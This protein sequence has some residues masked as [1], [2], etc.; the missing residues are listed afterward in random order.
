[1]SISKDFVFWTILWTIKKVKIRTVW[2]LT[3]DLPILPANLSKYNNNRKYVLRNFHYNM[4]IKIKIKNKI[5]AKIII[6]V[7]ELDTISRIIIAFCNKISMKCR[8]ITKLN[9]KT[10]MMA[11]KIKKSL[12]INH[13]KLLIMSMDRFH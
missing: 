5:K 7:K 1:M 6:K 10:L 3:K 13:K 8:R 9:Y 12:I 2:D 11:I 4:K